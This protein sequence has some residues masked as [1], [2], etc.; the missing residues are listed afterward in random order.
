[1]L[2]MRNKIILQ[3]SILAL[4]QA[5]LTLFSAEKVK[6]G[7]A[8]VESITITT[9]GE[10]ALNKHALPRLKTQSGALFSQIDFDEDLRTLAKEYDTVD[11]QVEFFEGKTTIALH[12]VAKPCIRKI[13]ILGNHAIPQHKIIKILQIYQN[14][15]YEREKFLKGMDDLKTYYLKRGY[16]E[17]K[18]NYDFDHNQ[19]KGCID[20]SIQIKEGPCGKIKQLKFNGLNS[21]EKADIQEFIQ[22]KQYSKTISWFTGAGLYHPD[23]IEQDILSITNYLHNHGYADA[24]VTPQYELDDQGNILLCINAEKGSRYTLG[25]VHID[26]FKIL[27]KRLIEKQMSVASNDLYCSDKV[28]D[29]AQKIK[30]AYARY[31][32]INTNVDV[33]FTPHANRPVY[34]ITYQVNEGSPYKVGLIKITGNTHTKSDV[35]LHETSL[36]PGNTFNRLKLENTE[37]RLRNTGYFQSVSV[38]TVRSQLDPM[39]NAEH[40]RD[41]FIEVKETT[42]GNLGLFLG[43]SS[44]DNLFGG[45]ELSESNFDL[46]GIRHFFSKGFRSLRGGGEYLFLKANFGDKVTDY[47]LKW[48]KPHFLNTPWILGVELEKS[49]NRA[50]SKDYAVQTYGGNVSTTYILNEHLKYGIFYRGS[51]TS[52]HEKRKFLL[53]PN[54]DNNKGFVSAGGCTLSYDSIDNPRNPTTGIRSGISFEVSGLGGTY[55]FTKLSINS[56]IYRKFTRKGVLKIKGEAQFIKPYSNTIAEGVPISERFFLGGETSVRGYKSFII[57]PKYSPSEPKGGLSSLL[58]SEEFQYPLINQPNVST[59]VFLD[60]GFIGLKEYTIHLKDLCSSAG[61]GLRFDV[62]NNVPV[63]LGFGWPFRPTEILNGEKIDVSQRFFFALGGMF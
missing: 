57:G 47:T 31:G 2:I 32:Y 36:F 7:Y 50:L 18:L 11:P 41:I 58:L 45:I 15:L 60:A 35:I 46:F 61:I 55:H 16:F 14:D 42:T 51:Q 12:L 4:I 43:F 52:L 37:Q 39:G 22:T 1:M 3:F 53:G 44:L 28:W 26:G 20:I 9:E 34:D 17:S 29:S 21:T 27:P 48:T 23:I 5:P 13:L 24:I 54:I 38:Y 30:Q 33:L 19:E 40:Y 8:I 25:H 62:M 56:A 59:F 6:E 49:I 63:M 10:N